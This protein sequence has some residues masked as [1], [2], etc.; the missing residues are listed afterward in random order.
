MG[1][2][3]VADRYQVG[4]VVGR[5]G[6]SEVHQ[7]LDR[8]LSRD[9]A[10][11]VLRKDLARNPAHQ[12]RFRREAQNA[13]SLNH[14]NIV[15][16][17][18]SGEM[19]GRDLAI[20][21]IV[22]E[23]VDGEVLRD[24]LQ[25]DG[26]PSPHRAAEIVGDVCL[27]LD[28][29]HRHGVVHRDIKPAN[30]MLSRSGTV[31]VMDFGVAR[32]AGGDSAPTT[33]TAVIGN[34][35]YLSPEQASGQPVD[36]RSD[37]YATGCML[38]ELLC[39]TPPFTGRSPIVVANKHVR[40]APRP[41]SERRAGIPRDLD[42]VVLKALS[43]NPMNR[44]QTAAEMRTDLR[45]AVAGLTVAATPVMSEQERNALHGAPVAV[46]AGVRSERSTAERP[47][48]AL[49]GPALAGPALLAPVR[50]APPT[51]PEPETQTGQDPARR[52]WRLIGLGAVGLAVVVA[53]VLTVL[54][55]TAPPPP[56]KV[57]VPDV[58]GL[59]VS[60]AV[61]RLQEKGLTLGTVVKIDSPQDL[62]GKVVNQRPSVRTQVDAETPV[63]LEVDAG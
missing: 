37:I 16:V 8:R 13:A 22:M 33:A 9:V 34:A 60:D 44:Y 49:A 11:K 42:A 52:V 58:T 36:A 55:V 54:V 26:P 28:F 7:G 56:A 63:N 40:E 14:P 27:A 31:K 43:K 39:G 35:H 2:Q 20:P 47:A 19:T 5:G 29:S 48:P 50:A 51:E 57:A 30:V 62:P 61:A 12:E 15:A 25:R 46:G 10:V 23:W 41:P 38:Y 45:R 17:Y 4:D 53:L 18:D 3:I 24:V 6:M 21:Y 1:Y 32:A 59:S